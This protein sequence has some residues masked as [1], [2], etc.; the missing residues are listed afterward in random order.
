[1]RRPHA[2]R[3]RRADVVRAQARGL[4]DGGAPQRGAP[5]ARVRPDHGRD[6]RRR[7]HVRDARPGVRG[8]R[9]REPRAEDRAGLH[10]GRPAR[11][12]RGAAVRDRAGRVPAWSASRP[13]SATCS[14][15][16]CARSRSRSA[17]ARRARRRCRTSATRSCP[18]ASRASRACCAATPRRRWRTSRSGTSATSRTPRAERIILPDSTILLDQMQALSL[19]LV[20]GMVVHADRM[21]ANLEITSGALF[22]Q[23]VLLALVR[24]RP[25]AR[26]RVPDRPAPRPAG[27]GHADAA[28]H[29][30]GERRRRAR[31]RRRLRL[32]LLHPPRARPSCSAWR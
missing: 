1:M 11:P 6:L 8:A 3:A 31:L 25:A 10:A 32:R 2:R 14:A 21:L 22:S 26:R 9:G 12:P 15:P 29:A 23:R 17:R 20:R 30:D 16:R 27:L 18:S 5:R 4:R 28:A 7:R 24:V 13:R 19:R